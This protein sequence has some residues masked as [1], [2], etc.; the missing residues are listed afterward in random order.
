MTRN[1]GC[2]GID[3]PNGYVVTTAGYLKFIE[4][5]KLQH[6]IDTL[7]SDIKDNDIVSLRRCGLKIR[8]L[9]QNA[10]FPEQLEK[11]IVSAYSRLSSDY[12]DVNGSEQTAT[13]V[14]VRSSSTAED[15]Q[16]ASFAGQQET[17][18]NVRGK[19]QVLGTSVRV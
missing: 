8:E 3:V 6:S 5:N 7:L 9:I 19:S 17:Y 11:D 15:L 14:A 13:D 4:H 10:E 16:N 12:L 2:F 18:L 1:L